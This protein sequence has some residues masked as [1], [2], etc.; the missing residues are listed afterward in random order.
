[1]V[2]ESSTTRRADRFNSNAKTTKRS[3]RYKKRSKYT[4]VV[5]CEEE[6]PKPFHKENRTVPRETQ[7]IQADMSRENLTCPDSE[8][9]GDMVSRAGGVL[10]RSENDDEH[11]S[12]VLHSEAELIASLERAFGELEAVSSS[13]EHFEHM[14]PIFQFYGRVHRSHGAVTRARRPRSGR[15]GGSQP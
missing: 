6:E 12:R 5:K 1:M 2:G 15:L 7:D 4:A 11:Q 13:A 14:E 9:R 3:T 10:E 8:H